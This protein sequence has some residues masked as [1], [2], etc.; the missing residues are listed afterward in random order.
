[1]VTTK[2]VSLD[3]P[4]SAQPMVCC[5]CRGVKLLKVALLQKGLVTNPRMPSSGQGVQSPEGACSNSG[6]SQ[7]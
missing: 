3:F 6:D 1:M 4:T 2:L 5:Q 7:T